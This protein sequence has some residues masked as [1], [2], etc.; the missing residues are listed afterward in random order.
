MKKLLI[1]F[2]CLAMILPCFAGCD[3]QIEEVIVGENMTQYTIIL[4]EK[5]GGDLK[6]QAQAL[7]TLINEHTG[8]KVPIKTDAEVPADSNAKE[9]LLGQTNRPESAEVL[10]NAGTNGYA[11]KFTGNKLVVTGTSD[12]VAADGIQ[13]FV[14]NGLFGKA[15][16]KGIQ[17]DTT[18][19]VSKSYNKVAIVENGVCN[20][21]IVYS[22]HCDDNNG[23]PY[24]E[25]SGY[26]NGGI[27]YEVKMARDIKDH[28]ENATGVTVEMKN[29]AEPA[30]GPEILVGKTNREAS[31]KFLTNVGYVQYGFGYVDGSIVVA[32]YST[33]DSALATKLL[34]NKLSATDKS[35]SLDM[36]E[37]TLRNNSNWVSAFP[38]YDGG[39]VRGTSESAKNELQYYITNTSDAHFKAYCDKLEFNGYELILSNDIP[40]LLISR[41]FT[42]GKNTIHAYYAYNEKTTRLYVGSASATNYPKADAGEYTKITDVQITQM[43]LDFNTNSG[44][45][46][47]CITLEDGSFIMIDSGSTTR[48]G[49]SA[50]NDHVR[51]WNLLNKLNKREDGK[52]IIRAWIITHAHS[53]HNGVYNTFCE[54]YGNKVTIEGHYEN[55]VPESVA[56]N[57]KNP[58]VGNYGFTIHAGIKLNMYGAE[59]EFLTTP[60]DIYPRT[61]RYFNNASTCFTVSANGT[62]FMVLGDSCDQMSDIL[63]KRYGKYLKSDIVQVAHHGNIGATSEVYDCIDPAVA[64]WPTSANLFGPLVDG[65]GNQRHFTV[66]YHLH[67][68]MNVKEHYTNGEYTVTLTLGEGGYKL[69]SAERYV[70]S[71]KDQYKDK[72]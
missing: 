37:A 32:G 56:Y 63:T 64:L 48:K 72:K 43:Q 29:D 65:I 70:V 35:I 21:S 54:V 30:T 14:H 59:I 18:L 39:I 38:S 71:T 17:M 44:G 20:F 8:V 61:I 47:Y 45:M 26:Y 10:K 57:S 1:I 23:D 5:A 31:N 24:Y 3:E 60:E 51:I 40:D 50:N 33:T 7:S 13:W 34:I 6:Q 28:I 19:E 55:P 66:N 36:G 41:T 25:E 4:A 15:G 27:D 67:E 2:L 9:F 46:G 69:G 62:K 68:E 22:Q 58:G 12:A 49:A 53:D 16:Y 42:N 52:I 11:V